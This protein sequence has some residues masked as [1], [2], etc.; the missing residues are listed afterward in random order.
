[1]SEDISTAKAAIEADKKARTEEALKQFRELQ[2]HFRVRFIPFVVI[3]GD[4][5][6][7]RFRVEATD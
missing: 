7:T 6:L 1:M 4:K 5:C 3:E 2:D